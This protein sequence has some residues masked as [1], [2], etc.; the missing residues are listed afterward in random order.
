[1]FGGIQ[2]SSRS[3]IDTLTATPKP[4]GLNTAGPKTP[5][6][7]TDESVPVHLFGTPNGLFERHL[8]YDNVI[9]QTAADSRDRFEAFARAVRDIL[10]QRWVST[11]STYDRLNP[12]R[13]YYLSMEFL[14]GRSLANNVMNLMLDPAVQKAV[15]HHSLDWA[16]LLEE[17]PDAALGNGGLGR[18]AACFLDSMAT[19]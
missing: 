10:S 19:M 5:G 6:T 11:E 9:E 2:V 15:G 12:K 4:A 3:V 8:S 18:L 17:E 16:A 1:M 13:I 7:N 14:I